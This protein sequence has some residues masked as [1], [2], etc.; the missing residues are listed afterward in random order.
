MYIH[1]HTH[2]YVGT[3]CIV[4]SGLH[5][6]WALKFVFA[7]GR[8]EVLNELRVPRSNP[9]RIFSLL[10]SF[11]HSDYKLLAAQR[12]ISAHYHLSYTGVKARVNN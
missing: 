9:G 11:S 5:L 10:I 3:A 8:G 1:T 6:N 4:T 7:M 12:R 2:I